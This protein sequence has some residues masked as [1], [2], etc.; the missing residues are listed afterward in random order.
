[1]MLI[2]YLLFKKYNTINPLFSHLGGLS[3]KE[4]L[5]KR[6]LIRESRGA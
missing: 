3:I 6:W 2:T 1:M 4:G 5:F